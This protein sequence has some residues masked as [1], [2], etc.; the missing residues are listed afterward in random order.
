MNS[1]ILS[2]QWFDF[3]Y[4]N[5]SKVKPVHGSLYFWL[6]EL[7]NRLGWPSEFGSPGSSAMAACGISS[8]NTYKKA[9]NDLT[10]F[11]FVKVKRKSV[12]QYQS[13][14]IAL[15]IIDKAQYKALDKAL[16]EHST[17]HSSSTIQSTDSINKPQTTNKET[18]NPLGSDEPKKENEFLELF[19]EITKRQFRGIG[20]KA[21]RQ[22]AKLKKQGF[23]IEDL[24]KAIRNGN[25]SSQKWDNPTLFT[26]EY[27]TRE[28]K[29]L[30]YLN[31]EPGETPPP[32][33]Y[34]PGALQYGPMAGMV[35]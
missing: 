26:P 13:C 33:K 10:E 4:E 14:I 35:M 20:S 23:T 25:I 7:A 24:K 12:N 1:Y 11:G 3:A 28:D 34:P 2:R 21:E 30:L 27:I 6:I 22:L 9:I 32:L 16:S 5:P 8:Y 29:F 18:T 15:S 19:N 31:A 17:K